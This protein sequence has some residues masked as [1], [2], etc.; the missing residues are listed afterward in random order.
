MKYLCDSDAID[1]NDSRAFELDGSSL[2][3]I[4]KRGEFFAYIN[5]CPHLGIRLEWVEHRFLDSE[6]SLI[7]CSTH[8]ALFT[9]DKGFCVSG[10]CSGESLI[11]VD[12]AVRGNQ[13]YVD[14]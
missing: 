3:L 9:I 1:I 5:R 8:G 6:R 7:Q 12:L 4:N 2:F 13:I 14:M 11:K 10:P